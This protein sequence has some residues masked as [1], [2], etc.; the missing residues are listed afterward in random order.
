M[1]TETHYIYRSTENIQLHD[2]LPALFWMLWA[3][4]A[5]TQVTILPP[6]STVYPSPHFLRHPAS[7]YGNESPYKSS[8]E[9]TRDAMEIRKG[10]YAVQNQRIHQ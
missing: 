7:Y 3:T 10:Y 4:P 1:N 2:R 8:Q 5:K 6:S 9:E